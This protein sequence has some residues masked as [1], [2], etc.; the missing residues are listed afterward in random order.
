M[1]GLPQGQVFE[2]VPCP[3][4]VDAGDLQTPVASEAEGVNV[5]RVLRLVGLVPDARGP[6]VEGLSPRVGCPPSADSTPGTWGPCKEV[7]LQGKTF[8]VYG[9]L[10]FVS[11][12]VVCFF[13]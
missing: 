10:V 13:S 7:Q 4:E 2:R 6:S 3:F 8:F 9:V 1:G 5:A 12:S 11:G